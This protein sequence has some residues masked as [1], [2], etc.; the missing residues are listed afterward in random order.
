MDAQH[1][2]CACIRDAPN[3]VLV[4]KIDELHSYLAHYFEQTTAG[5]VAGVQCFHYGDALVQF[6]GASYDSEGNAARLHEA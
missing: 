4:W 1:V 6:P 3:L 2:F 5:D